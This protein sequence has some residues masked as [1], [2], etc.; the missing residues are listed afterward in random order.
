M[1]LRRRVVAVT[2]SVILL[3]LAVGISVAPGATYKNAATGEILK[4][5]L[6]AQRINGMTIFK[7]DDG[8]TKYVNPDEWTV[9]EGDAPPAKTAPTPTAAGSGTGT[10]TAP[11]ATSTSD[12]PAE[13]RAFLIPISGP[14]ENHALVEAIDKAIADAKKA[15]ATV[16]V[17][18]MN[19][20]GGRLDLTD[21]IIKSIEKIDWAPVVA[22]IEGTDKEALSAGAYICLATNK[23]Y[24]APGCTIGAATPYRSTF[25][26]PS[27]VLEKFTSAFRAKFRSLAETRGYPPAVADAMV[28]ASTSVVQVTLEGKMMLVS[29]DE[30]KRLQDEHASDGKFKRGKTINSPGKLITLTTNEAVEFKICTSVVTTEAELA[31][32]LGIDPGAVTEAKWLP[33][34]VEKTTKDRKKQVDDLNNAFLTHWRQAQE[35]D[36]DYFYTTGPSQQQQYAEKCIAQLKECAKVI[37]ELEKLCKD[38]R[39][40]TDI[41]QEDIDSMKARMEAIYARL[42]ATSSR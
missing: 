19:T 23:I 17:L 5:T 20:P 38:D 26:G 25:M 7:Y 8:R 1:H 21:K 42:R 3:V 6:T 30:A 35:F 31:K 4:G 40:D 24:M 10:G 41:T 29:A 33:T 18:H 27:A 34:W 28:D 16:I 13:P 22:W 11:A 15:R 2:L 12:K 39:Y 37:T 9:I 36:P 14:I 32:T